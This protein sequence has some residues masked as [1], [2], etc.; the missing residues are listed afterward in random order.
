[1]V[2]HVKTESRAAT[3]YE[4]YLGGGWR[5]E[6]EWSTWV[7]ESVVAKRESVEDGV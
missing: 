3:G 2:D 5:G 1:M 7:F 4:D 6:G